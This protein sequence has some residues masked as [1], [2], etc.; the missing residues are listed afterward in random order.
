VK[1]IGEYPYHLISYK[2][3]YLYKIPI[4]EIEYLDRPQFHKEEIKFKESLLNSMKKHGMI[5]LYM[6]SMDIIMVKKLK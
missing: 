3:D 6:Q 4:E 2:Y 5:D 1:R